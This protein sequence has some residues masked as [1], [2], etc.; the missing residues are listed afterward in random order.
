LA[1]FV[2]F[3]VGCLVD[4][5]VFDHFLFQVVDNLG[6]SKKGFELDKQVPTKLLG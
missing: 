4:L 5:F 6:R 3:F 1:L 2:G